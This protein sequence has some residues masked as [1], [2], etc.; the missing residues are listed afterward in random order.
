MAA[1]LQGFVRGMVNVLVAGV[2]AP[3]MWDDTRLL[4]LGVSQAD[5]HLE[6]LD[7]VRDAYKAA[8]RVLVVGVVDGLMVETT[9]SARPPRPS[10]IRCAMRPRSPS[11]STARSVPGSCAPT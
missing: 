1:S 8:T 7:Q 5:Y 4:A 3:V 11:A 10:G 6:S 9:L 2:V